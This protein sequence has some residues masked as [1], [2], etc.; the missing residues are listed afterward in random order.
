MIISCTQ[1]DKKFEI[2]SNLIP[3]E[4][5]LLQCSSCNHQWFYKKN[6]LK[7]SKVVL[8][9][10]NIKTEQTELKIEDTD[11]IKVFDDLINAK[12][13][14]RKHSYTAPKG[15]KISFLSLTLVFVISV[16]ALI[17]LLD[18]FKSPI[19]LMIPNIEFVLDNLYETFK[20]ILLFIQD[21]I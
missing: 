20:D 4:G 21:L 3:S 10:E 13:V 1:C 18:T 8:K 11:N 16:S 15:K 5:R 6:V 17:V 9:K 2:E 12:S 19:N 7:K 14:K